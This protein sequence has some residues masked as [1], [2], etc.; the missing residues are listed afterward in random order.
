MTAVLS[1]TDFDVCFVTGNENQNGANGEPIVSEILNNVSALS[2]VLNNSRNV[3]STSTTSNTSVEGEVRR[4]FLPGSVRN[5]QLTRQVV[6]GESRN[7]L[8]VVQGQMNQ[9]MQTGISGNLSASVNDEAQRNVYSRSSTNSQLIC[10]NE[11]IQTT[12]QVNQRSQRAGYSGNLTSYFP[13]QFNF[14]RNKR[15]RNCKD[16]GSN[17]KGNRYFYKE[18]VLLTGPNDTRT[19]QQGTKLYLKQNQHIV[20]GVQFSKEWLE[21]QVIEQ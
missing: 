15:K 9:E 7:Q 14:T 8:N 20:R 19:P 21:Q 1:E 5:N 3:A 2:S 12:N 13:G 16:K 10:P 11:T 6:Q 18:I 4:I 17:I